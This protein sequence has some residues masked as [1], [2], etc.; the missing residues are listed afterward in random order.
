MMLERGVPWG[1]P[2]TWVLWIRLHSF[3]Q[4]SRTQ[5]QKFPHEQCHCHGK[6]DY[7]QKRKNIVYETSVLGEVGGEDKESDKE[8]E[9]KK[10]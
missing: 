2:C 7:Y 5:K 4:M 8:Q 1:S 9:K 10:K 3:R 6:W